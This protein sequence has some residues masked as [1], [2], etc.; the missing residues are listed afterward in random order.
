[1]KIIVLILSLTSF[2]IF[3]QNQ[4]FENIEGGYWPFHKDTLNY[5][6]S[7]NKFGYTYSTDSV[8]VKGK[9][10][11]K[12]S[13]ISK[14]GKVNEAFLRKEN[15]AVYYYNETTQ[16]QS[17]LLPAEFDKGDKWES[18]CGTYRYKIKSLNA[19]M[20]TPYCNFEDLLEIE[21]LNRKNRTKYQFF[22]KK[23]IGLLGN[24]IDEKPYSF[25]T[26]KENVE[27]KN[28]IAYGCENI[29]SSDDQRK[30]TT[31]KIIEFLQSNL[32]NPTPEIHG[33]VYYSIV[34]NKKGEVDEVTV[35]RVEGASKEQEKAGYKVLKTLPQFIPAYA[36][37]KPIKVLSTI[38]IAF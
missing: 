25:I 4:C 32:S 24:N 14:N 37:S 30:C 11:F 33:K 38:P 27:N 36:G 20:D 16:S 18:T 5:A 9:Y 15:N 1:M 3:G 7:K 13:K 8:L 12:R 19:T 28:F 6:G 26:P 21:I 10:Y 29:E 23:G 31:G 2:N 35:K 17:L 34:I 22:Y